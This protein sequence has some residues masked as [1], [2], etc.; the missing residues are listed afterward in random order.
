MY[1]VIVCLLQAG[2]RWHNYWW[3]CLGSH[4][5]SLIL[6][7]PL[8]KMI[9]PHNSLTNSV[10]PILSMASWIHS[11]SSV[12]S[13]VFI[14]WTT[15][16][17]T[18]NSRQGFCHGRL[19]HSGLSWIKEQP[20]WSTRKAQLATRQGLGGCLIYAVLISKFFYKTHSINYVHNFIC[21][22]NL[23]NEPADV[24][25]PIWSTLHL[26]MV[27]TALRICTL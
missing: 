25:A 7:Q 21:L 5:S 9:Q 13:L 8:E 16:Y 23:E 22:L 20:T 26:L 14:L 6:S 11:S 10:V 1:C 12:T 18:S 4:S 27:V 17:S 2:R 15:R 3:A 19:S 24:S